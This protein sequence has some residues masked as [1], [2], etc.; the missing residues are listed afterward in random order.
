MRTQFSVAAKLTDPT[1]L[2]HQYP[3][4]LA[5]LKSERR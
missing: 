3:Y 4:R 1:A 5:G 2:R